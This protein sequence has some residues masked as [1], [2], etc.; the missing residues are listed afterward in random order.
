MSDFLG[1]STEDTGNNINAHLAM[2]RVEDLSRMHDIMHGAKSN[3][4]T[5]TSAEHFVAGRTGEPARDEDGF[6][7]MCGKGFER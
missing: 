7:N 3:L 1:P 4:H 2:S 6:C 5:P